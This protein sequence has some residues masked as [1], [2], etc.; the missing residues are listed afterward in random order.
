MIQAVIIEDEKPAA[1][2]LQRML[3]QEGLEVNVLLN[4]VAEAV[5]WLKTNHA[6]KLIFT[7]IH[8]SDGH[9]FD[10]F[11]QV[12]VAS[13]IIFTTAYDQYAIKAFK[14][15]SIDYLLKPI[16]QEELRFA[17]NKYRNNN[18]QNID[19]QQL[20]TNIQNP[21]NYKERFSIQYG[22]HIKSLPVQDIICFYSQ[23]KATY[24]VTA[25]GEEFLYDNPLEK[26]YPQLRPTG[27]FRV[28]RKFII[29]HNAIADI[30]SYSNSRLKVILKNFS[31]HEIIVARERVKDFKKWLG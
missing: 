26:I 20:L 14:L 23:D 3:R 15:N 7:D 28:N 8:L 24:I 5:K 30:I 10:I 4:S 25:N 19:F 16:R 11:E 9:C 17:V 12:P 18:L 22:H 1:R 27:F 21:L 13:Q 2:R 31:Q 6:P 29:G